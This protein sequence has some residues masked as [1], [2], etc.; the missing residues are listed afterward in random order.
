MATAIQSAKPFMDQNF[1]PLTWCRFNDLETGQSFG[2]FYKDLRDAMDQGTLSD[3]LAEASDS[4]VENPS[5][6]PR[7]SHEEGEM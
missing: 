6:L 3:Q 2:G 1:G 7:T 5:T 4:A